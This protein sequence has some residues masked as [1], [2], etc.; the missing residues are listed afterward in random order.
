MPELLIVSITLLCVNRNTAI[1]G[2]IS[3][4]VIAIALP[5][6]AIPP[7]VTELITNG[8]VFNCSLKIVPLGTVDHMP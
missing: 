5:A 8:N 1:G 7:A 6:R 4:T 2:N 3:I